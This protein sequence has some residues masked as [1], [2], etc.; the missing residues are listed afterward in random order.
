[1]DRPAVA[2]DLARAVLA[3]GPPIR[4]I[5]TTWTAAAVG[6]G[7]AVA[8]RFS[9]PLPRVATLVLCSAPDV[10]KGKPNPLLGPGTFG[11]PFSAD[12][13]VEDVRWLKD[14][15]DAT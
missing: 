2:S 1:M 9:R 3:W 14:Q 6:Q 8:S 7:Y 15:W 4:E 12:V 13:T 5:N 11:E 10:L